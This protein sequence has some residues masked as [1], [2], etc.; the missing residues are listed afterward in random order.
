M[1]ETTKER[2]RDGEQ[3]KRQPQKN[4]TRV[5]AQ[6]IAEVGRMMKYKDAMK[7]DEIEE[8]SDPYIFIMVQQQTTTIL[9]D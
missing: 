3:T 6:K 8:K 1:R 7:T 4:H 5:E 9:N 2:E